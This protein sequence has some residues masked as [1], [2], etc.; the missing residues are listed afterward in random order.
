MSAMAAG[1]TYWNIHSTT[2]TGGEIRGFLTAVPEPTAL[3]LF[4]L[5]LAQFNGGHAAQAVV[6]GIHLEIFELGPKNQ[7]GLKLER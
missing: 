6:F 2:F 4:G 5:E 3:A 1:K 7:S